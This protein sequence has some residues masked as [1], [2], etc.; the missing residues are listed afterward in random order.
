MRAVTPRAA[1]ALGYGGA[2]EPQ[3]VAV[4]GAGF[5]GSAA[6]L[7]LARAGHEVRVFEAVR[8]PGPVGAGILIQPTG[9]HVLHRLGLLGEVLSHGHRVERLTC[10]REGMK[11]VFDLPYAAYRDGLFG[12]GLHR[13]VLFGTL[14]EAASREAEVL[15]GRAATGVDEDGTLHFNGAPSERFDLVIVADGARSTL[16]RSLCPEVRDDVYPFG[17]LW[18]V[19]RDDGAS[20]RCLAQHV[21]GAREMVG[22]LP[23]GRAFREDEPLSSLFISV[24]R[25]RADALKAAGLPALRDRILGLC[26]RAEGLVDQI[27]DPEALL[28][29][30]YRDVRFRRY[31][32]GRVVFLG[33]AAHAMSPQLGQGSNLAL[34][35]AKELA[36][37]AEGAASWPEALVAY[38]DAR[39]AHLRVYQRFTRWLTPF[40]QSDSRALGWIRDIGFPI[41]A[42]IPFLRREM[43][44]TLAGLK[45]RLVGGAL[46][47]PDYDVGSEPEG[48]ADGG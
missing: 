5:A 14:F 1:T 36:R 13:G 45:T 35:D 3:R 10:T 42:R 39:R 17:A 2:M 33:D 31:H 29:A 24:H 20:P 25:E 47:V 44:A 16:R 4:V 30:S 32:R 38:G 27:D 40:F 8:E 9:M 18:F 21:R 43:L 26:P 12:L 41:A 22:L 6:A 28:F 46:P 48:S 15:C 34:W 37:V 23:T 11:T 19:G 7:F